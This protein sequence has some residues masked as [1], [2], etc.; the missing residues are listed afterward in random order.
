MQFL[1]SVHLDWLLMCHNN[2]YFISKEGANRGQLPKFLHIGKLYRIFIFHPILMYFL[3]LNGLCYMPSVVCQQFPIS[4]GNNVLFF[5]IDV[6]VKLLTVLIWNG[7][8][9]KLQKG[10]LETTCTMAACARKVYDCQKYY[11]AWLEASRY[12][13]PRL[14]PV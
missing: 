14:Q 11:T 6:S 9:G 4:F 12:W 3:L 8:Q 10:C 5:F 2:F 1:Q 13:S 7:V